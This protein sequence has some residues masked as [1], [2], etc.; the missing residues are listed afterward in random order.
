MSLKLQYEQQPVG[1]D[2][3]QYQ[4]AANDSPPTTTPTLQKWLADPTGS[5]VT[6]ATGDNPEVL[7]GSLLSISHIAVEF[8]DI[9]DGRGFSLGRRLRDM[10]YTGR[11]RATGNYA[12]DQLQYLHR[13]GYDCFDLPAGVTIELA[14]KLLGSISVA[15][16]ASTISERQVAFNV[17]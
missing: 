1:H 16:Q 15:M 6:L 7:A 8:L 10:G 4:P 11:L 12:I 13:C 3:D 17:R 9:T 5:H 14:T 2:P